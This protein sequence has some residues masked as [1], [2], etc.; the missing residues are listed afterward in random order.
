MFD[1]NGINAFR[2]NDGKTRGLPISPYNKVLLFNK[3]TFDKY[4]VDYPYYGMTMEELLETAR[5][6]K[7]KIVL[8]GDDKTGLRPFC[9]W[10]IHVEPLA[11]AMGVGFYD[12]DTLKNNFDNPKIQKVFKFWETLW[13]EDLMITKE[14]AKAK[15]FGDSY[16][17]F[18]QGQYPMVIE[19]SWIISMPQNPDISQLPF[20]SVY[21]VIPVPW[22]EGEPE[23]QPPVTVH[24]VAM[25]SQ[26]KNVDAAFAVLKF[27]AMHWYSNEA[28]ETNVISPVSFLDSE[29]NNLLLDEKLYPGYKYVLEQKAA[30]DPPYIPELY[31][32][33]V[34]QGVNDVVVE[35]AIEKTSFKE[36]IQKAT[37]AVQAILDRY[38][39]E[40]G[41]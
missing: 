24:G 37:I 28:M 19:N 32:S 17:L 38:A 26:V 29:V 27:A 25:T 6:L 9:Q 21:D 4:G 13:N 18:V 22:F 16:K 34:W 10:E 23:V 30:V 31:L 8:A 15:G 3:M 41:K 7:E 35:A 14:E 40:K 39:R 1:P 33:I 20:Q 11:S 12:V 2:L 5:E 36:T